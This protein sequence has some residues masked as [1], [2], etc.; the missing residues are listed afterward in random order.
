MNQPHS[1]GPFRVGD[2]RVDPA[3]DRISNGTTEIKLEPRTMRLLVFLAQR[4]GRL[5]TLEEML[6]SVW[7][8]VVVTPASA[9]QAIGQLRRQLGDTGADPRFI[10]NV[11]R[12]GY[13]LIA[14]V[15]MASSEA[16]APVDVG[17]AVVATL[18][19][20]WRWLALGLLVVIGSAFW[21]LPALLPRSVSEPHSP[22][23]AVLPFV[24]M[25]QDRSQE[26]FCDGLTEELLNSLSRV[27]ELKVVARTSAFSFRGHAEDVRDIGRKLGVSH[28]LE[29][30]VRRTGDRVRITAQLVNSGDGFHQ[31]SDTFDRP[32]TDIVEV[33]GEIARAVVSAL[34]IELSSESTR[35][36][37]QKSQP[38][39]AAF[40]EYLLGRHYQHQ[41][42]PESLARAIEHYQAAIRLDADYAPA[43]AGL[44]DANLGS[45]FY[46][47]WNLND[48][49][50][51]ARPLIA[52]ALELDPQ[53]AEAYAVLGV[54]ET[55]TQELESA[56]RNLRRAVALNNNYADAYVRLGAALEYDGRPREALDSFTRAAELD[57][58]HF[59]LHTR[60]CLALQNLGLYAE[61]TQACERATNLRPELP[62]AHW[63]TGLI[64]LSRGDH[65]AA[66]A[67][68]EE[69]LARA[70]N[71]SDLL[72][73]LAWL[74]RDLGIEDEARARGALAARIWKGSAWP[75][76]ENMLLFPPGDPALL[77]ERIS[78]LEPATT[79]Y[80]IALLAAVLQS[81]A[82]D[83]AAA[84]RMVIRAEDD[85]EFSRKALQEVWSVRWARPE[86]VVLALARSKP[87]PEKS[88]RHARDL[89]QYLD[90]LEANGQVWHGIH[91]LRCD[92]HALRGDEAAALASLEK[93]IALGWRSSWWARVDPA[94]ERI[95]GS[96][97]FAQLLQRVDTSN[98]Q[99]RAQVESGRRK[100]VLH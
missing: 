13:S 15:E 81:I 40:E 46:A 48:A 99:L 23:I 87:E 36:L 63:A 82:G 59:N 80:D 57:P 97:R 85:P 62:N 34:R 39:V 12:R 83:S 2:W 35:D 64:A 56:E 21:L 91:Y 27:E 6:E 4:A 24:D 95:R 49:V 79:G 11:P 43:Y 52:K 69:A 20:S 96:A 30:S 22:S 55:E 3:F 88:A 32:F 16:V 37:A 70:P 9:Y 28:V 29:G 26:A 67:G 60:R 89:E 31:W 58:L 54:L 77:R 84:L 8:D 19:R 47:N 76:L 72:L 10:A 94:L 33:Q 14:P 100:P 5:V 38:R 7:A 66:I 93:A 42:T 75:A 45:Y 78:Q 51:R 92:L 53:S 98:A 41:R 73:Q 61:A 90:R 44:A 1:S 18:R 74:Y 68:Y 65:V 71:R 17:A 50:G 25:S 86:L